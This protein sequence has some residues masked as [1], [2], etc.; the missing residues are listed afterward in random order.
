MIV[1]VMIMYS[2]TGLQDGVQ[3]LIAAM[4]NVDAAVV[5][6]MDNAIMDAAEIIKAEQK[7]L[8]DQQFPQLSGLI[9]IQKTKK[10]KKT[11]A[12]I[13]YSTETLRQH[14]ELLVIEYGRPGQSARCRGL[15]DKKG[16]KKGQFP[17]QCIHIRA[18]Y[19]QAKDKAYQQLLNRLSAAAG[20][21]FHT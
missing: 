2:M 9:T 19:Q 15:T 10:G 14:P 7:R 13:G 1:V 12:K 8:L 3:A 6:E 18:G 5:A 16:R 11:I 21:Q 4:D 17:S 20:R